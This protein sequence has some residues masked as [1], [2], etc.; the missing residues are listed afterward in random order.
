MMWVK[1]KWVIFIVIFLSGCAS[2]NIN[3]NYDEYYTNTISVK[4][5]K[6]VNS[7]TAKFGS[8]KINT[9]TLFLFDNDLSYTEFN[10]DD[11]KVKQY[12]IDGTLYTEAEGNKFKMLD[13]SSLNSFIDSISVKSILNYESVLN[14][15]IVEFKINVSKEEKDNNISKL[16]NDLGIDYATV[17]NSDFMISAKGK[18]NKIIEMTKK[19]EITFNNNSDRFIY[20]NVYKF[21]DIGKTVI[22]KPD[23]LDSY[24]FFEENNIESVKSLLEEI[25]GYK[26]NGNVLSVKFNEN[27]EY[28]FDFEN[29]VFTYTLLSSSSSY[30]F[31]NNIGTFNNCT[32]DFNTSSKG[33]VCTD[34]EF[35]RV[36]DTKI[37]LGIE[38]DS[39][40]KT[41]SDIK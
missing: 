22:K 35:E 2:K 1:I 40:G 12:L 5:Y 41:L 18:E 9:E 10:Q 28:S 16:L 13:D 39:I 6:I 25:L 21:S 7:V 27:E 37:Y 11:V 29:N 4:N 34:E 24:L 15:E 17:K 30:N 23:D 33:G 38:L 26:R 14:N 31:K 8:K 36:K 19:I 3:A 32:Y 20:E